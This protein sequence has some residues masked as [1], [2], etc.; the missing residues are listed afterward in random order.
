MS[1]KNRLRNNQIKFYLADEEVKILNDK[2]ELCEMN[3]SEFLRSA[4]FN[5][6]IIIKKIPVAEIQS[7]Q[8]AMDKNSYEI[9]KIGNNI[10]QLVKVIHE[11]NDTYSKNQIDEIKKDLDNVI[12]EYEKLCSIMFNKLYGLE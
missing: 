8:M 6:D 12:K 11:N 10:N 5:T 7:A 2:A 9:N 4:I 1:K 3:I